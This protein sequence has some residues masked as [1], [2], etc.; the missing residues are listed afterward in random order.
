MLRRFSFWQGFALPAFA[1]ARFCSGKMGFLTERAGANPIYEHHHACSDLGL[2]RK[3]CNKG[4]A[5]RKLGTARVCG[6]QGLFA[7]ELKDCAWV[8][9]ADVLLEIGCMARAS[10]ALAWS[11]SHIC[12]NP[13]KSMVWAVAKQIME[14]AM[15][16]SMSKILVS[17]LEYIDSMIRAGSKKIHAGCRRRAFHVEKRHPTMGGELLLSKM[18]VASFPWGWCFSSK[19]LRWW[20][21]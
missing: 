21:I 15:S 12:P 13:D 11:L 6:S 1:N 2:E 8:V 16:F 9:V 20:L 4:L 7:R 14:K 3:P 5:R 10:W 18:R 19:P 17:N